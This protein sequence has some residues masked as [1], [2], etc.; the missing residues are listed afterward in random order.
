MKTYRVAFAP[1]AEA[2][3]ISLYRYIAGAASPSIAKRF[4]D[5]IVA[6]CEG[7]VDMPLR[8]APRDDI[9]RGLRVTSF[10]RRVVI[11]Y[12]VNANAITILGMFYGGQ[13]YEN[14]LREEDQNNEP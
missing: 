4:T 13:D 10:R 6:H 9:R 11:A 2:Q 8:G 3:L 12:A 7:F 14:L 5:S 1:E